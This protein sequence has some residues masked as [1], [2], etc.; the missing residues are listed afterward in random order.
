[1]ILTVQAAETTPLVSMSVTVA[2][3]EDGVFSQSG[4][5]CCSVREG[6]HFNLSFAVMAAPYKHSIQ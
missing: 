5:E 4:A 6:R 2:E 1:M 3:R